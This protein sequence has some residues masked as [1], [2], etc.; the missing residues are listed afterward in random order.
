MNNR[1]KVLTAGILILACH[2]ALATTLFVATNGN[3]TDPGT[4]EKPFTTLE[5]ARDE[6]RRLKAGGALSVGGITVEIRGGVYELARPIE[7][8]DQDSGTDTGPIVYRARRGEVV[9]IVG[10]RTVTGW[11]LVT[12]PTILRRLAGWIFCP[13]SRLWFWTS[14]LAP[15]GMPIGCA[16][17]A[18]RSLPRNPARPS[19]PSQLRS[20]GR[21]FAGWTTLAHL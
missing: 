9:R 10:G 1:T 4:E 17:W 2:P 16:P 14:G 21:G 18:M 3:D 13:S 20:P 15:V 7:L 11:R 6:I 5:R 8:T 19:E 12:T